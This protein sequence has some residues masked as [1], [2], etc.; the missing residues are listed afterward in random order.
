MPA[1]STNGLSKSYGSQRG[2]VDLDLEVR[3]GEVFGYLGP[4]GAGKTTTIRLLLDLIRPDVGAMRVLGLDPRA[5]GVALRG[6]IGY[7]PGELALYDGLTGKE[8]I[9]YIGHMRGGVDQRRVNQLV[10]RLDIDLSRKTRTLSHGNKQKLGLLQ[11]FIHDPELLILD[12]PT[13]G[14]DPLVQQTVYAILEETRAAGRTIFVSSHVLPEVERVCDRVGIIREGRLQTVRSVAE[15][16][17]QALRWVEF[18]FAGPITAGEFAGLPGVEQI[19]ADGTRIRVQV[20]GSMD[21]V[22]KAAARHE[23]TDVLTEEAA[24]E[25]AFLEYFRKEVVDV[26]P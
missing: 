14:L 9:D 1:I 4:N 18:V 2:I 11:A 10:E 25:E 15:I 24:L 16:K 12:E 5:D 19:H 22:V 20:S 8:L 23:V 13:N 17:Q 21:A 6:R 7:L 3:E 26:A